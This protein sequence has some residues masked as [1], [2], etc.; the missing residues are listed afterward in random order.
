MF[1]RGGGNQH[2]RSLQRS[3]REAIFKTLEA[4]DQ[5]TDCA[6]LYLCQR[7][8]LMQLKKQDLQIIELIK[9]DKLNSVF[10]A[11]L[12]HGLGNKGR[13]QAC[14]LRYFKCK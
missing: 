4:A 13:P 14:Q 1:G 10:E 9:E 2:Y 8:T 11:A 5:E 3:R 12:D 6:K 7:A